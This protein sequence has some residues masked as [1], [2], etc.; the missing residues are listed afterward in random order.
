MVQ[1]KVSNVSHQNLGSL[2]KCH[3]TGDVSITLYG[4]GI[5]QLWWSLVAEVTI[6]ACCCL[7]K[8]IK[9]SIVFVPFNYELG[10]K[11]FLFSGV[12]MNYDLVDVR[13]LSK[14]IIL[15]SS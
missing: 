15:H 13:D 12:M 11:L 5:T 8:M 10:E 14:L 7:S 3:Y 1:E 6:V 9:T 2:G 4:H